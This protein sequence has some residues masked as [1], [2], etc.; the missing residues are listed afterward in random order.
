MGHSRKYHRKANFKSSWHNKKLQLIFPPKN[1]L[2]IYN[3][4]ILPHINYCILTWGS[5]IATKDIYLQQKRAI[6]AIS[7]AG[8]KA[9]TE[10]LFNIYNILKLE[11]VY[12]YRML[13]LY[14]DLKNNKVP[15]Y[16]LYYLTS[17]VGFSSDAALRFAGLSQDF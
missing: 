3:A 8:Y 14:Y 17:W 11:D 16:Q 13:V 5:G 10:P 7:S 9:H 15:Y 2:S 1:F 6:R 4:L 12:N